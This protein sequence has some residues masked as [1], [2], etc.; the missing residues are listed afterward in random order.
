MNLFKWFSNRKDDNSSTA[1]QVKRITVE[2]A[3]A[4]AREAEKVGKFYVFLKHYI[5]FLYKYRKRD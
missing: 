2:K 1:N 4:F 5:E 3:L